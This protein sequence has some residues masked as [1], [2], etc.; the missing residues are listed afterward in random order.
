MQFNSNC[1]FS[2]D[3]LMCQKAKYELK[4]VGTPEYCA[5]TF[6]DDKP[7]NI[8]NSY[9]IKI[10]YTFTGQLYKLNYI[11]ASSNDIQDI[12]SSLTN[13]VTSPSF[14]NG[15]YFSAGLSAISLLVFKVVIWA[16]TY[17]ITSKELGNTKPV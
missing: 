11:Q 17:K 10:E 1:S 9:V 3:Y 4:V 15:V 6:V 14:I 8:N 5:I 13:L 7:G 2:Q 16:L 12:Q